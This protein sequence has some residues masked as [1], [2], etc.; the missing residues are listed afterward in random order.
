[1]TMDRT[2]ILGFGAAIGGH[3]LLLG[4]FA[5]GLMASAKTAP[6]PESISVSLVG[7]I[8]DVSSAPDAIQEESAPPATGETAPAEPP[9]APTPVMKVE[10]PQP[11]P[12]PKPAKPET[13]PTVTKAAAKQV[14]TAAAAPP[15][16]VKAP[17]VSGKGTT[18]AKPGGLSRSF[19]DSI[20][21]I[22]KAPGAGKAVGTP[23]TKT[24]T[25]VRRSV[26]VSIAG[27]IRGRVRACA[28]TGV[29]INKIE[30]FVTLSLEPSGRLAA[31]RF[32]RQT[33][34]NESNQPQAGLL[35]DC[36]LQAVR[37]A[38]PYNGLDPEYH[39]VWKTHALRL[40]ATG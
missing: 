5:L 1:M 30:T 16:T 11:K 3:A 14:K 10:K 32:D 13:A 12:V 24:A 33:G 40:R 7:E 20:N 34:I 39:D 26:G 18:P 19:E 27:Q 29:D 2:E 36:I 28:P 4:V 21:N 37:A 35:K 15:K 9:P 6:K 38:S 31:V 17:T 23:A 25:E 22:G 8:A